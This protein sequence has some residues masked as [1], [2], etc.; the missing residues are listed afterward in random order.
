MD[1]FHLLLLPFL[2]LDQNK[3]NINCGEDVFLGFHGAGKSFAIRLKIRAGIGIDITPNIT[4]MPVRHGQ[5]PA[6]H[7]H[8]PGKSHSPPRHQ[9]KAGNLVSSCLPP[10]S[11]FCET[12]GG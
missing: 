2:H 8:L 4:P 6:R 10:S 5:T 11:D 3:Y 7:L 1:S 12:S 9:G